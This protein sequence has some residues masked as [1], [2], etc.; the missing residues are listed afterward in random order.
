MIDAVIAGQFYEG[1]TVGWSCFTQFK[2]PDH[3]VAGPGFH[4][5]GLI[6]VQVIPVVVLFLRHKRSQSQVVKSIEH[7]VDFVQIGRISLR[8]DPPAVVPFLQ[9]DRCVI[10]YDLY[11][12]NVRFLGIRDLRQL[13]I[14]SV[15]VSEDQIQGERD[16]DDQKNQILLFHFHDSPSSILKQV[17]DVLFPGMSTYPDQKAEKNHK[18]RQ[19][20]DIKS[21]DESLHCRSCVV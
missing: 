1:V 9:D 15:G 12:G 16:N 21:F 14:G 13:V 17:L 10:L 5:N 19:A 11:L 8:G 6:L 2:V 3:R 20:G 4:R 7:A 18:G